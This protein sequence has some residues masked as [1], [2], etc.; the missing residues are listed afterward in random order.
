M[1]SNLINPTRFKKPYLV[2]AGAGANRGA[3][4]DISPGWPILLRVNDFLLLQMSIHAT[5]GVCGAQ[6]G[7]TAINAYQ[8]GSSD[9]GEH[10][11]YWKLAT[12]SESGTTTLPYSVDAGVCKIARIYAFR[13]VHTTD[14]IVAGT[15]ANLTNS[16]LA[17]VNIT[18]TKAFQLALN[19]IVVNDDHAL[20]AMT[21]GGSGAWTEIDAEYTTTSGSDGCVGAQSCRLNNIGDVVGGHTFALPEADGWSIVSLLLNPAA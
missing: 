14:P 8:I 18:A 5:S 2:T 10:A 19:M 20:S 17:D 12:G 16:T 7:W 11:L 15:S 4:G 13:N 6:S 3:L 1:I 21:G 9:L